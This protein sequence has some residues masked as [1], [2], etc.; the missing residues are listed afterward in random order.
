M[1]SKQLEAMIEHIGGGPSQLSSNVYSGSLTK[2]DLSLSLMS[3]SR[4]MRR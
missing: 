1:F 2:T 3:L 4:T